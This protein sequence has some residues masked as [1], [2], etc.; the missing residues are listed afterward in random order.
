M[1][2]V[3]KALSDQTRRDILRLLKEEDL[4]AGEIAAQFQMSKPA[5][6]K[7]L[8]ILRNAQLV[9][10][11]KEGQYVWYSINTSVLQNALGSFLDI[12]E[13]SKDYEYEKHT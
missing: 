1:S 2:D 13:A 9:T 5:I 3:F 7:H 11:K 4:C 10:S 12:F 6:T 8:D